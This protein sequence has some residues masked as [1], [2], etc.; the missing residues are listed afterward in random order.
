MLILLFF[1]SNVA[2]L[3]FVVVHAWFVSQYLSV[4]C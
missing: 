4:E 1:M 2:S 3:V